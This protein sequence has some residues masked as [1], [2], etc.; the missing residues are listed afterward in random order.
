ME[1]QDLMELLQWEMDVCEKLAKGIIHP[2]RALQRIFPHIDG[3]MVVKV[4]KDFAPL[5]IREIFITQELKDGQFR[6][7]DAEMILD[8]LLIHDELFDQGF[9]MANYCIEILMACEAEEVLSIRAN[10]GIC[11]NFQCN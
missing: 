7:V 2:L 3:D 8:Y 1:D 11:N 4:T 9:P 5:L 6:V 10:S